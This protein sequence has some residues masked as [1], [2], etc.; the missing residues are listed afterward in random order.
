[1][2]AGLFPL[3]IAPS[4]DHG[5]YSGGKGQ[6]WRLPNRLRSDTERFKVALAIREVLH[7]PDTNLEALTTSPRKG[8]FWPPDDELSPC[9]GPALPGVSGC[10]REVRGEVKVHA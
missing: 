1:M 9:P 10:R 8:I 6:M 7:K 5:I 4:L 2:I 3:G